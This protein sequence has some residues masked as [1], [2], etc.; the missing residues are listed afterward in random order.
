MGRVKSLALALLLS[1]LWAATLEV[2]V[3]GSE[4]WLIRDGIEKQLTS[5][6][7]AKLQAVLS[8]ARDR[9]AYYEQCPQ[10]ENCIPSIVVL[11][12]SGKRLQ[13]VRPLVD[14]DPCTSILG[15]EWAGPGT[16]AAECHVNPSL[17]QYL[18]VD[19]ASGRTVRELL[20]YDFT[21]SPDGRKVAHV[22][23]IVHFAP[24]WAQSEYLQIDDA[25]VYPLEKGKRPVSQK[26]L[27][28][29]PQM[30]QQRGLTF[31]GIHEFQPGLSWSPDSRHV[32]LI[33]CTFDWT[34]KSASQDSDGVESNRR[35]QLAVVGLDGQVSLHPLTG[36]APTNV[37]QPRLRWSN[38]HAVTLE[39]AGARSTFN[40]R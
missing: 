22:G 21:R 34:L 37:Q 17:G 7:K 13:S 39:I 27:P 30:V 3:R 14:Q 2:E 9:I 10:S 26:G 31:S 1:P 5:D 16:I 19:L 32:A 20:G 36:L 23:W 4:V 38:A 12:L 25:T 18:E 29:P 35:C 24:R 40:I 6:G 33:D 28:E 15:I 8:P 11:D